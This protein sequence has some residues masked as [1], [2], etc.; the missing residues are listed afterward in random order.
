[1]KALP[2]TKMTVDEFVPWA[3]AQPSGRFELVQGEIVAM[4]PERAAHN[5]GKIAVLD[6]LR[7][8][9]KKSG[10]PCE[11]FTDGTSVQIDKHGL[12]EPDAAVQCGLRVSSDTVIMDSPILVVEVVSPSP[13]RAD[14][15]A[16]LAEYFC[17]PSIF[18]YLII[19]PE[20]RVIIHHARSNSGEITTRICQAGVIR[21]DPPGFA[22]DAEDVLSNL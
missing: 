8:A 21:F 20:R 13:A 5:R 11:V 17:V 12:R 2:K 1:M 16:K 4:S 7:A 9:V 6:A 3:M 14:S 19:D 22:I 10:L 18:H 15:G